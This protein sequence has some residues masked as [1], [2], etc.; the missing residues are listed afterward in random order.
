MALPCGLLSSNTAVKSVS[1][2][3]G[4]EEFWYPA[5]MGNNIASP[6]GDSVRHPKTHEH[7][8]QS[9]TPAIAADTIRRCCLP[10]RQSARADRPTTQAD[11]V[12]GAARLAR[13]RTHMKLHG[14][15]NLRL[16]AIHVG[17]RL[18]PYF[19]PMLVA[20]ASWG[21]YILCTG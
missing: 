7:T 6:K 12:T 20:A 9:G 11:Q 18:L 10:E 5:L 1:L 3:W 17:G 14:C 19:L 21:V 15:P 8:G 4:P 13:A 16:A 2:V